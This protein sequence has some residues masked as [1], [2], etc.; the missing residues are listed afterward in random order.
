MAPV[1]A[2][3][4]RLNGPKTS[5]LCGVIL[6]AGFWGCAKTTKS[7][8]EVNSK[9]SDADVKYVEEMQA[10]VEVGRNMAGRLLGYYGRIEDVRVV[11]YVNQV[12]NYVASY[13]DYPERRYMLAILKH[14][15]VNAFACP[16]GYVLITMGAL[17]S[18]KTEA[19][20]ASILGHEVAHVG[21]K[22]MFDTLKKMK[23]KELEEATKGRASSGKS[24]PSVGVRRR[25]VPEQTGAGVVLAR[26]LSGSAGAGLNVLQAAQAGMSLITEKGLDK[27]LEYEADHEGVKYAIRAGYDPRAMMQ[28]L[29]RLEDK[30]KKVKNLEK[31]HPPIDERKKAIAKLLKSLK[32]N[33][34][35]GANGTE[36][37]EKV[38]RLFP[39]PEKD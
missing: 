29:T 28:F 6:A 39:K 11:G 22:H 32:A 24:D 9:L 20:L 14:E 27:E 10:E 37:F 13:S 8:E 23:Q 33:E 38:K 34:I 30:A 3:R 26:Y 36:R 21:K 35:I 7:G 19:E 12:A 4:S 5:A 16:G 1:Y 2:D 18:I 15:S 25:P 31:T 17:R